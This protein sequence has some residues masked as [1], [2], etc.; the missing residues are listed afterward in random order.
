MHTS[1]CAVKYG[2]IF[3]KTFF[4]RLQGFSNVFLFT[5]FVVRLSL[6]KLSKIS[7]PLSKLT[8]SSNFS[9]VLPILLSHITCNLIP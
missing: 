8:L 7:L 2:Y 3:L 6:P 5:K 4:E 1:S 9:Q